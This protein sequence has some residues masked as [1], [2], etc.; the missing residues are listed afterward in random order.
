MDKNQKNKEKSLSVK[1][2]NLSI[3]ILVIVS[4]LIIAS[5]LIWQVLNDNGAISSNRFY[6]NTTINDVNVAGLEKHEAANLISAKL[7]QDKDD[8]D[9]KLTYE[10][11]EWAMTGAD[12][13]GNSEI[14]PIIEQTFEKGRSGSI[15]E[16]IS[17][18]RE[19][20]SNGFNTN[21][22]Y[23]Y[24]LGRF[25]EKIDSII[26]EINTDPIEPLINFNPL[27]EEMFA[28]KTGVNGIAVNKDSLYEEIDNAFA[29]SKNIVV[30]IPTSEIPFETSGVDLMENTKLR[31]SFSTSYASSQGGRKHNVKL[32]ISDFN[33]MIVQPE[34]EVSFNDVTGEKT[35]EKGYKK[36][37]IILNGVYVED[38]GGGAC[39][40]STTLY[41][42]LLLS[43]IEIL[44]VHPH[45]LPVSYVPLAFDAMVSEGYSDLKFR[46]NLESPIYIK[47]WGDEE[48]VY[49]N[50]YGQPL[51]SGYEIK[52]KSEF[53]EA[54][55]HQGDM[56]V[57]DTKGEYSDK[58]TYA[59]EYLRVKY[60]QEGYHSKGYICYY[61]NGELVDQKL[62]R[63]EVYRPQK[64]I[65]M[66]GTEMLGEGM[67][68][69][70]NEV[71]IMPPQHSLSLDKNSIDKKLGEQ[72][73]IFNP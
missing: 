22:S 42:A 62:I 47:T 71:R 32:S 49:V 50:I 6:E 59:G 33:G 40:A 18:V 19:I 10:G 35:P 34:Q 41:N 51:E 8:I 4:M 31:A 36:A 54:I 67:F 66:E 37:K 16:K 55:P 53:I 73:T 7:L 12:F 27:S 65:I 57:K 13:E 9:I 14:F 58:I 70:E 20:R 46:N 25:D 5:L 44:E 17:T 15:A 28:V 1:G 48:R 21:I 60:P 64:G 39:Q 2:L 63:D 3:W 68:I 30:E 72:N 11:K 23:R 45:S 26:S 29:N 38:Y 52:R 43:D 24:I 69:P 56:I 61:K